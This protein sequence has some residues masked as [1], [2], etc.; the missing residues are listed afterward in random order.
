WLIRVTLLLCILQNAS[1]LK[2]LA[3]SPMW[4]RS[5]V[6][7]MGRLADVLVEEGHEVTIVAPIFEAQLD[8]HG[9]KLAK[10]IEIPQCEVMAEYQRD[11]SEEYSSNVW[12]TKSLLGFLG[13]ISRVKDAWVGQCNATL[14]DPGLVE[15]LKEEKFDAAFYELMDMCGAALFHLAGIEK[16]ALTLSAATFEGSFI[17]TGVPTVSSYIPGPMSAVSD[18]M[19][20]LERVRNFFSLFV[21]KI[22]FPLMTQPWQNVVNARFGDDFPN[23]FEDIAANNSLMFLNNEPLI[24]FPRLTAHKIIDIGGITLSSGHQKLKETWSTVFDLRP[25][26]V[27]FSLGTMAKSYL[28]PEEY[29]QT[30]RETFA[31]FPNV[32]F[33][34][35]YEKPEHMISEGIDNI[36]ETV[37]VPQND[38]LYDPRLSLF[39]THCGQGS[40][41][42]ATAAGVPLIAIPVLGD[43]NRNAQVIKRIRTGIVLRKENLANGL[44][45]ESAIREML[46][47]K[48][49]AERARKTGEM[50]RNRPFSP[51]ETFVKNMEFMA[52]FGP[53]RMFDHYGKNLNFFQYYLIDVIAFLVAIVLLTIFVCF[54]VCRSIFRTSRKVTQKAKTE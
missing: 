9:T 48:S 7:F 30:L 46:S 13:E 53:L 20:F 49:Y 12:R 14:S 4:G 21:V 2:F 25:Q 22:F 3:Y 41:T 42:E 34:W 23:L 45:L 11:R 54:W 43:Q 8:T 31:K 50:I 33:I 18:R 51:R 28:M 37:W 26:T 19:T 27:L 15:Y 40:T 32:T 6:T 39:I 36:Y 38:M 47:D 16:I 5:H 52:R 17:Y 10:V 35:K 44:I 1:A 24:E 29:K